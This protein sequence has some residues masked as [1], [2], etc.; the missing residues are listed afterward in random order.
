M[1]HHGICWG[2]HGV[3]RGL[4]LGIY[5][6]RALPMLHYYYTLA[7]YLIKSE[8]SPDQVLIC[9]QCLTCSGTKTV[10]ILVENNPKLYTPSKLYNTDSLPQPTLYPIHVSLLGM[11]FR[12]VC[13]TYFNP[14]LCMLFSV[15]CNIRLVKGF[16]LLWI[17][18]N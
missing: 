2:C 18:L 13:L 14:F 11:S 4:Y 16:T 3:F 8:S 10:F 7:Y 9:A 15:H 5:L 6:Y 12:S 1:G 17:S